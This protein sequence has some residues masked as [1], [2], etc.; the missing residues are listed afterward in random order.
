ME[1]NTNKISSFFTKELFDIIYPYYGGSIIFSD[2]SIPFWNYN[3]FIESI[4]WM[5][6]HPD[7]DFHNFAIDSNGNL[8]ILELAAFLANTHQETGDPSLKVPYPYWPNPPA[9][10]GPHNGDGGGLLAISEGV[11]AAITPNSSVGFDAVL[12]SN[13][14]PFTTKQQE[15]TGLSSISAFVIS[16]SNMDQPNFGLSS[17]NTSID[18]SQPGLVAVDKYGNLY[19]DN[20]LGNDAHTV[21]PKNNLPSDKPPPY[22]QYGGRGA[23]Q[24]SYNF[25]YS[26]ISL[27]LFKDYRL[28]K[29]PNLITTTNRST[30]NNQPYYF[31]FPGPNPDGKN[32]LPDN[33]LNTTPSAKLMAWITSIAFWMKPRS[34]RSISCHYAMNDPSFGITTTNLIINNQS[35]CTTSWAYNKVQYYKRICKIFNINDNIIESS[36]ICPAKDAIGYLPSNTNTITTTTTTILPITTTTTLPTKTTTTLPTTTTTTLQTTTLPTTIPYNTTTTIS[37]N[38]TTTTLPT[39]TTTTIIPAIEIDVLD[40]KEST[41]LSITSIILISGIIFIILLILIIIIYN[42][43]K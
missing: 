22:I 43:K 38:N 41:N 37:S 18:I 27:E 25:N 39:N 10:P 26:Q 17:S 33:I 6:K 8:N 24:L 21:K 15:I 2:D 40:V 36:I 28:V 3:S 32:N 30:F 14:V 34:G 23:I 42:N 20:P 35:G 5:N 7:Q 13:N 1:V 19:G 9:V 31:G 4:D 29:Y 11:I 16:L 12:K